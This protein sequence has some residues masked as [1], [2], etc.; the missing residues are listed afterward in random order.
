MNSVVDRLRL[1]GEKG[2]RVLELLKKE[3]VLTANENAIKEA[4]KLGG[5]KY[6]FN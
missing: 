2:E 6:F 4:K 1:L 3:S 5:S